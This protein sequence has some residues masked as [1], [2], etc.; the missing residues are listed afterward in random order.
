[1]LLSSQLHCRR[2]V[3]ATTVSIF[4]RYLGVGPVVALENLQ[5]FGLTCFFLAEKLEDNSTV[6]VSNLWEPVS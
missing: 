6:R 3:Y 5:V 1:M 4:D 2:E